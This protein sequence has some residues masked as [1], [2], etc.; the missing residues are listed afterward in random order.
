MS[1]VGLHDPFGQLKHTL[2]PKEGSGVKLPIL[3]PTI[4][5]QELPNFLVC[6]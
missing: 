5:S 3:F 2:W 1:E 6:R 4:K